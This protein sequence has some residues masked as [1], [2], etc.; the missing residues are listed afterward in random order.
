MDSSRQNLRVLNV[1]RRKDSVNPVRAQNPVVLLKT[2]HEAHNQWEAN[3]VFP[4]I[5]QHSLL[6]AGFF[7]LARR[8]F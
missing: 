4:D 7:I 6:R 8:S 2:Y 3:P 1:R 5:F